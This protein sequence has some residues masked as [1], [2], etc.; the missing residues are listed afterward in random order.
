MERFALQK[1]IEWKQ[2]EHRKPLVV[3]GARQ[4][5]KTWLVKEFARRCFPSFAYI[6]CDSNRMVSEL[7]EQDFDVKRIIRGLSAIANVAIEPE[8][9]LVF[10]ELSKFQFLC[11]KA[12]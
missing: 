9:T 2:K 12:A 11:M 8:K 1:L 7:F 10:E 4:V 3:Q 5:G 6:N